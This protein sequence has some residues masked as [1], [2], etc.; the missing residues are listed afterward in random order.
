MRTPYTVYMGFNQ[1][2][3]TDTIGEFQPEFGNA[4]TTGVALPTCLCVY[5][6]E[7]V[8]TSLLQSVR[9]NAYSVL[10]TSNP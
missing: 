6:C 10:Y 9:Y 1:N 5:V 2:S 4:D 3:Y 7:C 8:C